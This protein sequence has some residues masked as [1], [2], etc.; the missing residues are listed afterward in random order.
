MTYES[1]NALRDAFVT[2]HLRL[3]RSVA[4]FRVRKDAVVISDL[5][6]ETNSQFSRNL[7]S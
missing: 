7:C 5:I 1:E 4:A 2:H 6:Y 3:Q